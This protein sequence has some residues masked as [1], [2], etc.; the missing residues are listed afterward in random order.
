ML[1]PDNPVIG[2]QWRGDQ[3]E[4]Q[5]RGVWALVDTAGAVIASQ[6]DADQ[7][8]FARSS[9]KSLQALALLTSG[10][11]ETFGLHDR[12]IALALASHSGEE[13]HLAAALEILAAAGLDE[14]H[15]QCGPSRPL[16]A[17]STREASPLCHCCS[18]KHAGFLAATV[19]LGEDPA[20][21]LDQHS[22]VQRKVRSTLLAMTDCVDEDV[23]V[24][25]DGCS[26]PTYCLPLRSL[27]IGIARIANADAPEVPAA[28]REP[29][30]RIADAA[31]Q[32]PEMVAGDEPPRFDTAIMR[33]TSG[34]LFSK[35]G[36][37]GVQVIGVRGANAA[38]VGKCDDGSLRGILPVAAAVLTAHGHLSDAEVRL[39]DQWCGREIRNA[40]GQI[41]GHHETI[42]GRHP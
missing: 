12:H 34:R 38:F 22:A 6:G 18:G 27:A 40:A 20:K 13:M 21:Y 26:A 10:A 8:I 23:S 24:E 32:H 11:V 16:F 9:S 15:L 31:A 1:A 42:L 3:L 29:A 35:S 14:R 39:L 4:S 36:A 19:V 2:R 17:Q 41:T 5:H 28:L 37:D 25:I 7:T 33:A 30:R